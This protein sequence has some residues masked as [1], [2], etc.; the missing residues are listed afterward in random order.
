M[1]AAASIDVDVVVARFKEP[2]DWLPELLDKVKA[3]GITTRVV[4]YEKGGLVYKTISVP[5][6]NV[7]RDYHTYLHHIVSHWDSLAPITVFLPGSV[8]LPRK[9]EQMDAIVAA[10]PGVVVNPAVDIVSAEGDFTLD[11]WS[12]TFLD[13]NAAHPASELTPAVPRPLA[14][15]I[16]HHIGS[17]METVGPLKFGGVYA[18][19]RAS[20]QQRPYDLYKRLL[21]TVAVSSNNEAVH[22]VERI[23]ATLLRP[24]AMPRVVWMLWW[25]GW[26]TAPPLVHGVLRTWQHHNPTWSIQTLDAHTVKELLPGFA[27]PRHAKLPAVSDIVRLHLLA[28]YGGV[29]AD[30]TL[31]CLRP[32]DD[33]VGASSANSDA[34]VWMYHGR[35][36]GRGPA[37]WFML[38]RPAAPIFFKWLLAGN[39]FWAKQKGPDYNYFWMD[40]T[41][42]HVLRNDARARA[43]WVS[44]SP[45]A[46]AENSYSAHAYAHDANMA[47]YRLLQT[48]TPPVVVKLSRHD[49]H[50]AASDIISASLQDKFCKGAPVFPVTVRP[51]ITSATR[52]FP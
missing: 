48:A 24:L 51:D 2:L 40:E 10:L 13:N 7:G 26:D 1:G 15:W 31:P 52:F 34:G 21:F 19:T 3:M 22:Y 9:Q 47:L 35:D 29:W 28:K 44:I 49:A 8:T 27:A 14:A 20:I 23:W 46:N 41:L 32:L 25:Q 42:A 6:L 45:Y 17:D 38:G 30:A 18:A 5:L 50:P 12:S 37:S 16:H 33:W 39:Q 4:V 11:R 36:G 43:D